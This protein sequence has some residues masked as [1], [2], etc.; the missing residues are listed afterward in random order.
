MMLVYVMYIES[1]QILSNCIEAIR[2]LS[3]PSQKWPAHITV[4][5]PYKKHINID[6]INSRLVGDSVT[7]TGVG[8]FSGPRQNTVYFKC[9]SPK[10]EKVW[11]KRDFEFNPHITIYDGSNAE[12]ADQLYT[13]ASKYTYNISFPSAKLFPLTSRRDQCGFG[14]QTV[15]SSELVR[16]IA[17]EIIKPSDV[18][19]MS[20]ERKLAIIDRICSYLTTLPV[21]NED[22]DQY[23]KSALHQGWPAS[24][25]RADVAL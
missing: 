2:L 15:F 8:R 16:E 14:L 5:G 18:A 3:D 10:L 25:R 24:L 20:E 6:P 21:L 12:F 23:A 13:V 9:T 22:S 4:R 7:I 1:A 19:S 11:M 17:G